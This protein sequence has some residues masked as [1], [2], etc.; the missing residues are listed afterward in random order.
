MALQPVS[1]REQV[2]VSS[3]SANLIDMMGGDVTVESVVDEGSVF[4]ITLEL[5]IS[6]EIVSKKSAPVEIIGS[7]ILVVDDN[8]V[9]RD[10][11]SEQILHWK[12]QSAAVDGAEKGL[13]VF[14]KPAQKASALI[15]LSSISRCPA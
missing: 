5:P 4:T 12:C 13:S 6:E 9:N 14:V 1:M 7:K 10:I 15:S 8:A 11:L 3:I 2:S